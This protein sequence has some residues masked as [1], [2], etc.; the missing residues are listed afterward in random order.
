MKRIAGHA[1]PMIQLFN[2]SRK[3]LQPASQACRYAEADGAG[4]MAKIRAGLGAHITEF[5]KAD[6]IN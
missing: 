2:K 3:R 6:R 5:H 1:R 4:S